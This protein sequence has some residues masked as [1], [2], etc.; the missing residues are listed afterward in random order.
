MEGQSQAKR[1]QHDWVASRVYNHQEEFI[2]C[3]L[4]T[5]AKVAQDKKGRRTQGTFFSAQIMIAFPLFT[6]SNILTDSARLL[7]PSYWC[8]ESENT[9]PEIWRQKQ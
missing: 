4:L 3:F 6:H 7:K 5:A 9:K 2:T 8:N 1:P